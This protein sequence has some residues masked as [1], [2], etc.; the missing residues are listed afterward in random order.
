MSLIAQR[1][2][3]NPASVRDRMLIAAFAAAALTAGCSG[4]SGS[5]S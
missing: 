1:P 5:H 4:S 2:R 3:D